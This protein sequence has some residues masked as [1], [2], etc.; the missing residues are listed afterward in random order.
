MEGLARAGY[1][2]MT[3]AQARIAAQ[4]ERGGS[5]ITR[6]AA[7][8]QVTKQTAGFLVK[9]LEQAGYV[10]R[11]P[12]PTDGRAQL[13]KVA[14]RGHAAR[15]EVVPALEEVEAQ[16]TAHIGPERMAQLRE[17]LKMLREITDPFLENHTS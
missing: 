7:A 15:A 17:T 1:T 8:A 13:V 12:D 16:W 9:Q 6:L 4:I 3:V 5:R 11:V 10:E 14:A 2:D